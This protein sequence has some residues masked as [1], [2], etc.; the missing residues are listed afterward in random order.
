MFSWD[1]PHRVGS[2]ILADNEVGEQAAVRH[3]FGYWSAGEA[4]RPACQL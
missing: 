3:L 1:Q 4:Q 2:T